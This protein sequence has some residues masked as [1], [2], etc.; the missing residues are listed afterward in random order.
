MT[1][2][3]I[4]PGDRPR[5]S[6]WMW[7]GI[8]AGIL[9]FAWTLS[10]ADLARSFELVARVGA[11]ALLILLPFGAA[12]TLQTIAWMP[13]CSVAGLSVPFPALWRV[14]LA[15]EALLMS[16][17][18]GSAIAEAIAPVLLKQ[19]ADV[20]IPRGVAV[21]AAKKVLILVANA[22]YVL[23]AF[24]VGFASLQHASV[25][26]IGRTGL[27]WLV[28]GTA[29]FLAVGAIMMAWLLFAGGLSTRL[30]KR[31][32]ALPLPGL[33]RWL[34]GREAG[35][36]EVDVELKRL[37]WTERARLLAPTVGYFAAWLLEAVETWLILRLLGVSFT[38][39]ELISLEVVASAVRSMV[40]VV[41]SGLGVQDASYVA[42]FGAY[43]VPEP[44][45]IG[46]A[47]VILKRLKEL[48]WIA[49]GYVLL[50]SLRRRPR[51]GGPRDEAKEEDPLH[52]RVHQPDQADAGDRA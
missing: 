20:P 14:K 11:P 18:A 22:P 28:L 40:A 19:A 45:T 24:A 15:S 4:E 32:G 48:A 31:L 41:P 51:S 43:G 7:L 9:V 29:V 33:R 50:A 8:A 36:K 5:Q 49:F 12:Q 6:V 10:R 44:A 26:L 23:V 52:L 46:A 17:P 2:S 27:E 39:P 34:E 30:H 3:S 38:I 47:F 16:L 1:Q 37:L 42:F 25:A 35:F 13:L 21:V